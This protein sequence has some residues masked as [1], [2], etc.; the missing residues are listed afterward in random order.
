LVE[1]LGIPDA[2][3]AIATTRRPD[4]SDVPRRL[5]GLEIG[6]WS[7]AEDVVNAAVIAE[8]AE[9]LELSEIH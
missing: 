6:V 2:N 7:N 4:F 8:N 3:P 1:P 9:S 5:K